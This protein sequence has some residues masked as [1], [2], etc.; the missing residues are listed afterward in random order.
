MTREKEPV[1]PDDEERDLI[2]GFEAALDGGALRP[3]PPEARAK[4]SAEGRALVEE[5]S[6]RKATGTLVEGRR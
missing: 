1:F 4:A 6:A 3:S 5:A 2:E